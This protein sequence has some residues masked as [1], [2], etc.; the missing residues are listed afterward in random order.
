MK[1]RV[2]HIPPASS[3]RRACRCSCPRPR[4]SQRRRHRGNSRFPTS[5]QSS[6]AASSLSLQRGWE[7]GR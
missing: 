1:S 4:A 6:K 5:V 7:A 2:E 3:S